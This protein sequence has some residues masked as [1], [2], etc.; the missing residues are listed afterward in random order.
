MQWA[1]EA[2]ISL[3][4]AEGRLTAPDLAPVARLVGGATLVALSEAVHG[5]AEPLEFR[6]RLFEHLVTEHG[7]TAI[8]IESGIVES[9]AVCDY[10]RGDAGNLDDILS[11]GLSWNFGRLPQNQDVI[12]WLREYNANP[13]HAR[14]INFYGFDLPG[15]PGNART[16][17]GVDIALDTA[18][19]YLERVDA[20]GAQCLREGLRHVSSHLRFDFH[21]PPAAAGYDRL[22]PDERDQFA[23]AIAD[24]IDYLEQHASQC[25]ARTGIVEYEWAHLAA[26]SARQIDAWLR[27]I[28][29]GW[30]PSQDPVEFPSR[31]TSFIADA[32]DVRDRAQ[33]DNLDWIVRR[34]GP[35]G[36][37][38]IHGHRYH[39]SAA[40]V[41]PSWSGRHHEVMGTYLRRRYGQRL[42]TL[43][44]L[45]GDGAIDNCG[46]IETL[47]PAPL[48]SL[49]QLAAQLSMAAGALDLR[50]APTA[51]RRWLERKRVIGH[52]RDLLELSVA[53]AYDALI[54]FD[55][56]S[57]AAH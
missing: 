29:P 31:Q 52:G 33:A 37:I 18:M 43:G 56:V 49:D 10:V 46:V 20:Q 8:A 1:R 38:L 51:V 27:C 54:L 15:S 34:E 55:A 24:L 23:A 35:G 14:K 57:P 5:A 53:E 3:A 11:T 7:F 30:C 28:P 42:V 21:R 45:I 48:E 50:A 47:A 16:R 19:Q 12:G 4:P 32:N 22:S 2:C 40:P 39:L 17:V 26:I 36:K 9:R 13:R 6:N 25:V 44:N 41:Q